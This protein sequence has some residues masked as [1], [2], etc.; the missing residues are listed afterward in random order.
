MVVLPQQGNNLFDSIE[1]QRWRCEDK[2]NFFI[3]TGVKIKVQFLLYKEHQ[4][5]IWA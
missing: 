4:D 2:G 5:A 3:L 1:G